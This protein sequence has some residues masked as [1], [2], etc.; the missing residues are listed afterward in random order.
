MLS[1]GYGDLTPKNPPEVMVTMVSMFVSC[2]LFAYIINAIWEVIRD[3]TESNYKFEKH[4]TAI[5][6]FMNDH[7]VARN[8]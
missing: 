5:S 3:Y 4:L 2:V 6:R 1:V 7:K 8:L